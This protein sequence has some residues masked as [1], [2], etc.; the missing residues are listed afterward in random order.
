MGQQL[1]R[2]KLAVAL[3][4]ETKKTRAGQNGSWG[5][6]QPCT[7]FPFFKKYS[8]VTKLNLS[9]SQLKIITILLMGTLSFQR[10][11]I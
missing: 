9:R 4:K 5:L 10:T 2:Y 11:F 8:V 7:K 6:V 1:T 3:E